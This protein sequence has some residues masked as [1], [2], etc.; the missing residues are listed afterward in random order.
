[1]RKLFLCLCFVSTLQ[2]TKDDA[3]VVAVASN[4][5][6]MAT[7]VTDTEHD[8]SGG[9]TAID[10]EALR[11]DIA[12]T[13]IRLLSEQI[14]TKVEDGDY[15]SLLHMLL[16]RNGQFDGNIQS[17]LEDLQDLQQSSSSERARLHVGAL[18]QLREVV[19][20][21]W[22]RRMKDRCIGGLITAGFGIPIATLLSFMGYGITYVATNGT[23]G[24]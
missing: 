2:A 15:D 18:Y 12:R 22:Y 13:E 1:M 6:A 3:F 20:K 21:R 10:P 4:D 9:E 19:G 14:D 17:L 5:A 8:H 11:L 23:V 24:C 16:V 7:L